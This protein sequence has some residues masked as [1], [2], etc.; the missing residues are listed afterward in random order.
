MPVMDAV[1]P[2]VAATRAAAGRTGRRESVR[3]ELVR[4][5]TAPRG[6]V[7]KGI[8]LRAIVRRET[9]RSVTIVTRRAGRKAARPARVD[10]RAGETRT[11]SRA[12]KVGPTTG[13]DRARINGPMRAATRD[14]NVAKSSQ[15]P[16]R[17][18]PS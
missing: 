9:A 11:G 18:S 6:I 4:T 15:I 12:A 8:V 16:T 7:S 1:G 2:S 17:R 10:S 14:P 13:A 5:V 3:R